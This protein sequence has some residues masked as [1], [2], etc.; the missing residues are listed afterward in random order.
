MKKF[1]DVL[2]ELEGKSKKSSAF[3]RKDFTELTQA[4]L[5][6]EGYRA[7][8]IKTK[9]GEP[10]DVVTEPVADFRKAFVQQ[11]LVDH[12]V[13]K[14]EAAKAS[15][16]YRFTTKQADSLYPVITES[17]IQYMGTG[18]TFTFPNKKDLSAAIKLRV[19]DEH[20]TEYKNRQTGEVTKTKVSKHRQLVKKSSA[21][22]WC[23][24]KI[25]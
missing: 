13:D 21:P 12:G 18:R 24:K 10:V 25:K 14:Q 2:K 15:K 19:I 9:D 22:K 5:N 1:G 23:K 11:V 16:T 17:L 4:F 3:S 20:E 6:A 8:S 7:Y